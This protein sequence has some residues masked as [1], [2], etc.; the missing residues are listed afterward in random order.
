MS[1]SS[2]SSH[3]PSDSYSNAGIA[4]N[5]DVLAST[6]MMKSGISPRVL[7]SHFMP[8]FR[9]P[10]G[11]DDMMLWRLLVSM[12]DPPKRK[13][14]PH[15]NTI[16][17]AIELINKS[18]RI[19]VLSGAGIS[20]SAGLPD[21]RSRD[22]IYVQIHDEH[23]DLQDPKCMFD[24]EYFR[25][26]PL[27]FYQFAKALYP[28]Q[29][30]PT[31][32]HKFIKCIEEHNKLLRNYSQNIDTLEKQ[33]GIKRVVECH[34]SF[35]RAT[36]TNCR[37]SVD[38]DVIKDDVLNQTVPLCP[39]CHAGD[40]DKEQVDL[41]IV[42]GSSLKV[43]PVALIPRSIPKQVPQILINKEPLDHM[44]F[45]I[46]LLGNCDDI[47]QELCLRL[48][49][50]WTQV[51]ETSTSRLMEIIGIPELGQE[52]VVCLEDYA[53][54]ETMSQF[55]ED[56]S[57]SDESKNKIDIEG[58]SDSTSFKNLPDESISDGL[59]S[60][61]SNQAN[62]ASEST[63]EQ[64][65]IEELDTDVSN[66]QDESAISDC[67][68]NSEGNWEDVEVL[69][70]LSGSEDDV[71]EKA[72]LK[73]PDSSYIFLAPNKYLFKGAE[74]TNA[75]YESFIKKIAN[76]RL[77]ELNLSREKII[78]IACMRII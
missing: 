36:C 78:K 55:K 70:S 72:N 20:T 6:A 38:G 76:F 62:V 12:I 4:S 29:F 18:K 73:V 49:N 65:M 31:I 22:G 35:A 9:P 19:L 3:S 46:E 52:L 26:N 21:F 58:E 67:D 39:K 71:C 8:S 77:K 60:F 48:G 59:S 41:L 66:Q 11:T 15:F 56:T 23:P 10:P 30:K 2:S 42:V 34:G 43:K 63:I 1:S 75:Q 54:K 68:Q 57:E 7:L 27:P 32:G 16:D 5:P 64:R 61:R 69:N 47:I 51:C 40:T 13:K 37:Y 17:D 74:L 45:D 44:G 50:E 14:L 24:I 33:A 25:K 53:F 28:G